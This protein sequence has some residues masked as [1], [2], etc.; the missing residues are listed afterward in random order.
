MNKNISF[1]AKYTGNISNGIFSKM[2]KFGLKHEENV[3]IDVYDKIKYSNFCSLSVITGNSYYLIDG[4]SSTVWG[5]WEKYK[6]YVIFDFVTSKILLKGYS[7]KWPCQKSQSWKV[8]GSF[9]KENYFIID[10]VKENSNTNM[11]IYRKCTHPG[12]F[13]YIKFNQ[14][15]GARFHIA[16][17]ELF[18]A[19]NPRERITY[20]NLLMPNPL[21][22]FLMCFIK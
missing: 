22:V 14:T 9:D 10:E 3:L 11:N 19:F 4:N 21:I 17:I 7:I 5:N 6:T 2:K 8:E 12:T 13:R 20:D 1:T 18:G 16:D 15:S